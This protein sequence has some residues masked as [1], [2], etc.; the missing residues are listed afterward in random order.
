MKAVIQRVSRAC[1]RV[2][3]QVTGSIEGGFLV[4]LG[5]RR[6][7][8]AEA[9]RL[10]AGKT[11]ALRVFSD[12]QDKMNLSLVDT[13]GRVLVVSQFTLYA[14]TRKGNRPSF[15]H[16]APPEEA[17]RLYGVYVDQLRNILGET[18]VATGVFRASMQVELVNDGPVTIEL[19]TDAAP[20]EGAAGQGA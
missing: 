8:T 18:R 14:D 5:V 15:I 17:E 11:A 20:G 13:G 2:D 19:S 16:A 3:G 6:G 1:V 4:L 10:L 9:A 12:A 7:D